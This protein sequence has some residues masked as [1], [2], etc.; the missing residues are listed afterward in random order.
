MSGKDPTKVDRTGAYA[1]RRVTKNIVAAGLASRCEVQ[2][3]YAIG[4]T[5]PISVSIETFDTGRVPA[6]V[7][8]RAVQAVFDLRPG[9]MIE[10]LNLRETRYAPL[11]VYGHFEHGEMLY[12]W[13]RVDRV[14]KLLA[15]VKEN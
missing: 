10:R 11:A 6:D 4:M 7:L 5:E 1:A 8:A 12:A 2:I 9:A 15:A 14:E 13:E 3:A